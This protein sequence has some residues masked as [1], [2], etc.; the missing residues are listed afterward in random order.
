MA[1]TLLTLDMIAKETLR[2]IENNLA[3]TKHVNRNYSAEFAKEGAKIGDTVRIR[4]PVRWTVTDGATLST[5]D[6]TEEN[7]SL[8]LDKRKHIGFSFSTKD[9]TLSIDDFADRYLRT[10]AA[11]LANKIDY[12][13]LALY[14][15]VFNSVGTPGSPPSALSTFLNGKVK[16][17]DAGCPQDDMIATVVNPQGEANLVDALKGLFHSQSEVSRQYEQGT[18]GRAGGMKFSMS[19]NINTHTVGAHGGAP[20]VNGASQTGSSLVTDGW[21]ASAAVLKQGDVFT[22]AGVYSVNPQ[23]RQSTGVLQQFIATADAT[24]SGTGTLT[25]SISPSIVT[26]GATQTVSNSPADNAAITVVG[27]ASTVSPQHLIYHRDAFAFASADL[28]LP[29]GADMAARV[30][31]KSLGISIRLVRMYDIN[32]DVLPCRLD[33]LYGWK[34]VY[35]ELACRVQG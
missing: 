7:T 18:M 22:I 29:G 19:Q 31:S 9:L 28:E 24:A 26:S 2:V 13:G 35:P 6:V 15:S 16:M 3:F 10:A 33:V 1:N 14:K 25:V 21:T 34:A 11:A 5:Q 30:S 17:H 12:D 8:Q 27:A 4:K 23:S 32:N 20:L